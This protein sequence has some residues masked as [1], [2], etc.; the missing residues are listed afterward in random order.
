M[1]TR[2]NSAQLRLTFLS[3]ISYF[4]LNNMRTRP[5]YWPSLNNSTPIKHPSKRATVLT[6]YI[7]LLADFFIR[8]ISLPYTKIVPKIRKHF[9]RKFY[10]FV[11]RFLN[12][13]T[14]PPSWNHFHRYRHRIISQKHHGM[15]LNLVRWRKV[16]L[17]E[18]CLK[19]Y[20]ISS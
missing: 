16:L 9:Y 4:R 14:P 19:R 15:P 18:N 2:V 8:E 6:R 11:Y 13:R 1:S 3:F 12:N 20:L 5:N 10:K 7:N 17:K